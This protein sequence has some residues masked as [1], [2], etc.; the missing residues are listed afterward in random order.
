MEALWLIA[1]YSGSCLLTLWIANRFLVQVSW[2][3]RLALILLPL[4]LVGRAVFTGS[5]Y[6]PL[7]IAYASAPLSARS[8]ELPLREYDNFHLSDVAI[9]MVPWRRAVREAF[10][11]ARLPLWNPYILSGDILLAA[12]QPAAFHPNTWLGLLLRLP[13]AWTFACA[14]TFFSAALASFLF[15]RDIGLRD[16]SALFGASA[17]MLSNALVIKVGWP[18]S[19][20]FSIL[21]LLYLGLRRLARHEP[22]GLGSTVCALVLMV[23]GGHGETL[24]HVVTGAGVWFLF[25]LKTS[26]RPIR[27]V[28]QCLGAGV[29]T[30]GISAAVLLPFFEALPQTLEK[31]AREAFFAPAKK[32]IPVPASA[33][34]MLGLV[35]PAAYEKVPKEILPTPSG[36]GGLAHGYVGTLPLALAAVGLL[37]RRREKWGLLGAGLLALCVA[38]GF[39]GVTDLVTRLPLYDIAINETFIFVTM[40]SVTALAAIGLDAAC[41]KGLKSS[42]LIF[43]V[44]FCTILL[45]AFEWR[46]RLLAAG[47]RPLPQDS[48]TALTFLGLLPV[49][50]LMAVPRLRCSWLLSCTTASLLVVRLLEMPRLYPTFPTKLFY[51][52]IQ[53]LERLPA[54]GDPYRVVGHG[55]NLVQNQ[56]ILYGFE[57]PRGYEAM[58]NR[59][60][61]E[62][63]PL[64]S[65]HQPVWFNRVDDLTTPFLAFLNVR[66]AI[67]EP[68]ARPPASWREFARGKHA[69]VF[70][71]PAALPRAFAPERIRFLL[72]GSSTVE[73]MRQCSD[74]SRLGWIESPDQKPG[75]ILNG[76]AAVQVHTTRDGY[77]LRIRAQR[78]TWI[79]TS[80][81]AWKGWKA[82]IGDNPLPISIANHAFL[83]FRVPAGT[84]E[85]RLCY[86]PSSVSLGLVLTSTSVSGIAALIAVRHRGRLR[87]RREA[88]V[89]QSI[90]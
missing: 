24:L 29:L 33:A 19:H 40:F 45:G 64:W 46:G 60:Y 58:T 16:G 25:Q 90:H 44:A 18:H 39:P 10:E 2:R 54:G 3:L 27:A 65:I 42:A 68:T 11:S 67:A 59:R 74:F 31:A 56:S 15:L 86:W 14:F 88:A 80:V 57:D 20:V 48:S 82:H 49:G 51:P 32:S 55:Y 35:Y 4:L 8:G 50:V 69:A 75:E 1:V 66:F 71:N 89:I 13:T 5:F 79:I 41:E 23:F 78:P 83:G 85:V 22:L 81:T 26:Q 6:G 52:R 72:D 62:T 43:S 9:Q 37:T 21:P 63:Y 12:F 77:R 7:N 53:E 47:V 73:Q 61:Y 30:L 87:A 36:F 28:L 38:A 34:T 76:P 17:W 70:E 84:N